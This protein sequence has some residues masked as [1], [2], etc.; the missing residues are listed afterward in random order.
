[1]PR[2]RRPVPT[3]ARVRTHASLGQKGGAETLLTTECTKEVLTR[4]LKGDVLLVTG[5]DAVVQLRAQLAELAV[6]GVLDVA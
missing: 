6:R 3:R 2:P 5:V 4:E 1:M